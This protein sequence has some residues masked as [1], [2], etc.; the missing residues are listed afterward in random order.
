MDYRLFAERF[1]VDNGFTPLVDMAWSEDSVE[2][3]RYD[4]DQPRDSEGRWKDNDGVK[5]GQGKSEWFKKNVDGKPESKR[6]GADKPKIGPS[7]AEK[8]RN[9]E[10]MFGTGSKQHKEAQRRFGDAAKKEAES[11][12]SGKSEKPATETKTTPADTKTPDDKKSAKDS[13]ADQ[14]TRYD[15]ALTK[16]QFARAEL[17]DARERAVD[18]ETDEEKADAKRDIAE[19][20]QWVTDAG[21][22][23]QAE[24]DKTDLAAHG[25]KPGQPA[26]KAKTREP[27]SRDKTDTVED[28]GPANTDDSADDAAPVKPSAADT[29]A[30][31]KEVN[32]FTTALNDGDD[33]TK[34]AAREKVTGTVAEGVRQ[35][36]PEMPARE[37][38][39]VAE[40]LVGQYEQAQ[41]SGSPKLRDYLRALIT[42]IANAIRGRR[43]ETDAVATNSVDVSVDNASL[44]DL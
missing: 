10:T 17:K 39:A 28:P 18:A 4:P 23:Y 19:A 1:V 44:F 33:S 29:K 3:H 35:A 16:L 21:K 8:I 12:P 7:A 34:K 26:S 36:N 11:K 40:R 2:E 43:D 6:P 25:L 30:A 14:L 5:D 13:S 41:E 9:A 27:D 22:K 37:A 24:V 15:D 38:D 31:V 20:R 42:M 32:T